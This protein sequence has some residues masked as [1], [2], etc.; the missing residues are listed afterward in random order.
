VGPVRDK[1]GVL[2]LP[3]LAGRGAPV[4]SPVLRPLAVS[5][6]K[7]WDSWK[8]KVAYIV[9][10]ATGNTWLQRVKSAERKFLGIV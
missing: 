10:I 4:V 3:P 8:N 6:C 7:K 5:H 9:K 2:S 1:L